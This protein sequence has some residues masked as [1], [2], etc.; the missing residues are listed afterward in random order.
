MSSATDDIFNKTRLQYMRKKLIYC[1]SCVNEIK[2]LIPFHMQYSFDETNSECF[3]FM[4]IMINLFYCYLLF[5]LLMYFGF[6][7]K[8][9]IYDLII[10]I[11][12]IINFIFPNDFIC[13]YQSI[14]NQTLNIKLLFGES[15]STKITHLFLKY[16]FFGFF[17]RIIHIL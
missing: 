7:L 4:I 12:L 11:I 3:Q 17:Y 16:Y 8:N 14:N 10:F 6:K 9:K 15:C 13:N 5:I 2:E 1:Y